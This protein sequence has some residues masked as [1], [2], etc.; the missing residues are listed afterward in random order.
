MNLHRAA[1]ALHSRDWP[2][3]P[4]TEF[5]GTHTWRGRLANRALRL[6]VRPIITSSAWLGEIVERRWP[7]LFARLPLH[8]T[9]YLA[10]PIRPIPGTVITPAQLPHC[11]AEW[12]VARGVESDAPVVVY[13]HG[14]AWIVCGLRSHRRIVSRIS[15]N[16]GTRIFNVNY[17]MLPKWTLS[18][19]IDDAVD[20]YRHVLALGV[21]PER[22][23][24]AGD[25]AG[26]YLAAM[27]GVRAK[28]LGLPTPAGHVLISGLYEFNL[29]KIAAMESVPDVLFA[30]A[31]LKFLLQMLTKGGQVEARSVT[32]SDLAGLG[33]CLI[34]V[35]SHE[36][37]RHDAE[38][39]ATKLE[40]AGVERWLQI[41]DQAP[42]V[43]HAGA[44]LLPDAELALAEIGSFISWVTSAE[45]STDSEASRGSRHGSSAYTPSQIS[46]TTVAM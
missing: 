12:V 7:S 2:A 13:Y 25:S 32:D 37:L 9:D 11:N 41:W 39:L 19:C 17:R 22:I 3:S 42:H 33:R 28:E 44:D 27:V 45:P 20:G 8:L 5:L 26:G 23:V 34:Q 6:I 24:L 10:L 16:S 40:E 29:A 15:A 30:P 4:R 21:P 14:G 1:P 35:G 38:L 18:D 43:F 31:V 36:A 46:E